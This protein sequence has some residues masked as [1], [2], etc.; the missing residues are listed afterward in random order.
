MSDDPYFNGAK[1]ADFDEMGKFQA[2]KVNVSNHQRIKPIEQNETT[3]GEN[4]TPIGT[5]WD[6]HT[7]FPT[8][9]W[10]EVPIFAAENKNE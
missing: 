9:V 3:S 8:S 7:N 6:I 10:Q 2:Q 5:K 1:V 4:G